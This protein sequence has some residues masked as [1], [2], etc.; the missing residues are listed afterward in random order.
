[1]TQA[2]GLRPNATFSWKNG[3]IPELQQIRMEAISGGVLRAD[4]S[5]WAP[6]APRYTKEEHREI[7]RQYKAAKAA[8]KRS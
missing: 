8:E 4:D 2:L 1:M 3:E 7:V 5:C 6:A